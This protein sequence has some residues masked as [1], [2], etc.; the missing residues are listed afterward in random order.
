MKRLT[1]FLL[2]ATL[3]ACGAQPAQ[4]AAAT[5]LTWAIETQPTTLNPQVSPKSLKS[6]KD[7]KF[8]GIDLVGTGPFILDRYVQGQEIH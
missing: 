5:S 2:V 7:L 3:A 6:A 4:E 1:P 8:G